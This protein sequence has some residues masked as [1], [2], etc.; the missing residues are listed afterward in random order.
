VSRRRLGATLALASLGSLAAAACQVDADAFQSR[1][2]A[3]NTAARD[4]LCGTDG[5]GAPMTCFAARQL[6]ASDFCAP[7]C[8][9]V[10][11]STNE[12][13]A[14][15]VQG[16]AKLKACD[17]TAGDGACGRA[18][19]GCLRT[20]VTTD[21]GVCVTTQPCKADKDCT[22]P[23]RSTCATTFFHKLYDKNPTLNTDNL[24]CLQEGCDREGTACSPGETCL[25]HVI[26]AAAHPPDICVPKCDSK[27][28][29]PPNFFCLKADTISG[30]AN[31][32]VCIPG[33]LGFKCQ[34]DIDCLVGR[35][36]PDGGD[37]LIANSHALNICTVDCK[38]DAD[39]EAFDSQQGIFYCNADQHCV[40]PQAYQGASCDK[41][42]DCKRDPE[43]TTCVFLSSDP[44]DQGTCLH[45]CPADG[46]C[47]ALGGVNHTCLGKTAQSPGVCFP[48]TFGLPCTQDDNCVKPGTTGLTCRDAG[49]AKLCTTLCQNDADC[50]S[51]RFTAGQG[52]CAGAIC[53]P[54]FSLPDGAPCARAD[55]CHAKSC[56]ANPAMSDS[57]PTCGGM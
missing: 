29:C 14:V 2:F 13:G 39:C 31:P 47:P 49:A 23:V 21:Q 50:E 52:F 4:P 5:D 54:L 56:A 20:D 28:R 27:L 35:C 38:S 33:L 40:T 30:P 46:A 25:K 17:P 37:K 6:G 41:Q 43:T 24:Y 51:N 19:L 9:Y 22:D 57:A 10:A 18:E 3:C 7:H 44:A 36:L 26:P 42:D 1:I 15:C 48:G 16:D 32:A 53:L 55:Q 8:D 12:P 45:P 11:M 34:D